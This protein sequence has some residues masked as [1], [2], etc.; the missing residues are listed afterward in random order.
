MLLYNDG[1]PLDMLLLQGTRATAPPIPGYSL[2]QSPPPEY[3]PTA[4]VAVY[5]RDEVVSWTKSK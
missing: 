5:W 1:F 2:A 3:D 4:G